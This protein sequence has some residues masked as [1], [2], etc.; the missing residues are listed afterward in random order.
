MSGIERPVRPLE[1]HWVVEGGVFL[2]APGAGDPLVGAS[3]EVSRRIPFGAHTVQVQ[4]L[5]LDDHWTF[6]AGVGLQTLGWSGWRPQVLAATARAGMAYNLL[7]LFDI[8]LA[9]RGGYAHAADGPEGS[10]GPV[11][12]GGLRGVTTVAPYS[13]VIEGGVLSVPSLPGDR[14]GLGPYALL[15]GAYLF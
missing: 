8:G 15:S 13:I 6:D 14:G 3:V 1:G 10:H 12:G 2:Q 5:T 4:Q 11:W 9:V 7:D